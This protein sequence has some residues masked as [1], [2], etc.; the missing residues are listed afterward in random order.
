M[1]KKEESM[2]MFYKKAVKRHFTNGKYG[3]SKIAYDNYQTYGGK[4]PYKN[5]VKKSK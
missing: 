3:A 1:A 5:I 4:T 2:L